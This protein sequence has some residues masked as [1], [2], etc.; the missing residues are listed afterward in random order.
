MLSSKNAMQGLAAQDLGLGDQL[1]A[2]L[3]DSE[4]EMKKKKLLQEKA[5]ALGGS[6]MNAGTM[7]LYG[8]AGG[9][10]V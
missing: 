6:G 7:A 2:Q 5:A 9:F 1:R 8:S 10:S 3:D 4:A